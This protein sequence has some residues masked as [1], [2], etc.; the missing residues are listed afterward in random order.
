MFLPGRPVCGHDCHIANLA[1]LLCQYVLSV[2]MLSCYDAWV[3]SDAARQWHTTV[4]SGCESP[5]GMPVSVPTTC[6]YSF[7]FGCQ[8]S[9][10]MNGELHNVTTCMLSKGRMLVDRGE[11]RKEPPTTGIEARSDSHFS[12]ISKVHQ[13]TAAVQFISLSTLVT[14]GLSP[15]EGPFGYLTR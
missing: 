11:C 4:L 9:C 10:Y 14:C 8:Q 6:D 12:I 5:L 3:L 13:F 1:I 2:H 7:S 15:P